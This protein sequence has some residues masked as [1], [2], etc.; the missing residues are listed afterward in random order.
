[1]PE[2]IACPICDWTY[3]RIEMPQAN[4]FLGDIFGVG[5]TSL[6]AMWA[7]QEADRT[8]RALHDHLVK[9]TPE[10][11]LPQ[12]MQARNELKMT[13]KALVWAEESRLAAEAPK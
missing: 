3:E 2:V 13:R 4:D 1:M 10:E 11:W 7:H 12:L 6:T 8:E 5:A 9:H